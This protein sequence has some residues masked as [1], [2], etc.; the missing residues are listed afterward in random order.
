MAIPETTES[1]H[2]NGSDK[3]MVVGWLRLCRSFVTVLCWKSCAGQQVNSNFNSEIEFELN[4]TF[5]LDCAMWDLRFSY[6]GDYEDYCLLETTRLHGITTQKTVIFIDCT[7][8]NYKMF[9]LFKTI[10][11][12]FPPHGI[13]IGPVV[14]SIQV[15]LPCNPLSSLLNTVQI[16]GVADNCMTVCE[17]QKWDLVIVKCSSIS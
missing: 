10:L 5:K 17:T 4:L 7:T 16:C 13:P 6:G 14:F 11:T 8:F 3:N 9:Y 2:P 1:Q 15:S 12:L